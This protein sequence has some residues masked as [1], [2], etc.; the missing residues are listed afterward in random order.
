MNRDSIQADTW[1]LHGFHGGIHP[2]DHKVTAQLASRPATPPGKLLYPLHLANGK[3][4]KAVVAD[5]QTVREGDWLAEDPQGFLPPLVA[6]SSGTVH[7][8]RSVSLLHPGAL[9]GEGIALICDQQAPPKRWPGLSLEEA[10][11]WPLEQLSQRTYEAGIT[12]MGGAGFPSHVKIRGGRG[13][14]TLVV[15]G[16]ECEPYISCDDRLMQEQ[17]VA[18]LEGAIIVASAIGADRVVVGIEDNKPE[19]LKAMLK[20]REGLPAGP[21]ISIVSL[22]TLY[23]SGGEKQLL[24]N[25]F[26]VEIP[27]GEHPASLGFLVHNVGTLKAIRD[28]VLDGRPMTER[29]VTLAGDALAR[30]GNYWCKLGTPVNHLLQEAGL[31]PDK[32]F[33]VLHGGP[34]MGFNIVDLNAPINGT[35]NCLLAATR[36]ELPPPPPAMPC[37][38]CGQ[39]TDVCPARLLPQQLYWHAKA[40]QYE[41]MKDLALDQ[42]I[43]CGACAWVCPSHIPL[44][45]YY[46]RAKAD[47]KLLDEKNRKAEQARLRH[48]RREAR[49]RRLEEEKMAKRRARMQQR[50][51]QG[52]ADDDGRKQAVAEALA[53]VQA[54]KKNRA[55]EDPEKDA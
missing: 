4:F 1:Q 12:G 33:Q 16:A 28:A 49:L 42:C 39:C 14:K 31:E 5:G 38:R 29:M 11:Q 22:P 7:L 30:P 20:A 41:P 8:T 32:L 26:G 54:K 25:L 21:A 27:R 52:D 46:R 45:D 51:Q 15:N 2:P 3:H 43:E 6:A 37:I 19:A 23:P 17:P 48:E 44:V 55:N 53:R 10:L 35:S 36:E 24:E 13:C 9:Q 47:I 34:M 50:E 40:Q 18:I